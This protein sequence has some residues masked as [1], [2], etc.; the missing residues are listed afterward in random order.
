MTLDELL[1]HVRSEPPRSYERD[2]RVQQPELLADIRRKGGMRL[3]ELLSDPRQTTERRVF[4]RGHLLGPGAS[5]V[6][7]AT[8]L[9]RWPRHPLPADLLALLRRVNGIHL[10][11]DLDSGRS[12]EGL[13]PLAEWEPSHLGDR[14]LALSYHQNGDALI[15]LDV[16]TGDYSWIDRL[17][18]DESSR[19]ARSAGELLDWLWSHRMPPP[20]GS[21]IRDARLR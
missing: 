4:R 21:V 5:E 12:Y 15:V 18:G 14:Y 17:A 3:T 19:I 20:A 1:D 6:E 8:W 7:I 16:E 9:A 10:W 11:A 2:V 13:A